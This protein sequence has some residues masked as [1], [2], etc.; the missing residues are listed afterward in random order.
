MAA[1]NNCYSLI[2]LWML[3]ILFCNRFTSS[4]ALSSL[5]QLYSE[6]PQDNIIASMVNQFGSL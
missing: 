2:A 3:S 5:L 1:V 4:P 6:K